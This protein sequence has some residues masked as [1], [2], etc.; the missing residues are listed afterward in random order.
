MKQFIDSLYETFTTKDGVDAVNRFKRQVN[1]I[2]EETSSSD[3][4]EYNF[5]K[6]LNPGNICTFFTD[7]DGLFIQDRND[8]KQTKNIL[9]LFT[10][11]IR[12]NS[13]LNVKETLLQYM[14]NITYEEVFKKTMEYSHFKSIEDII[15]FIDLVGEAR[16]TFERVK[17]NNIKP[18]DKEIDLLNLKCLCILIWKGINLSK[19]CKIK[20]TD[21]I[22]NGIFVD[23]NLIEFTEY[24]MHYVLNFKNTK[25]ERNLIN[26]DLMNY[27]DGIYLF[28]KKIA[29]K[30]D[31]PVTRDKF[32]IRLN[33]FNHC[34]M[35]VGAFKILNVVA[36][37][38][39]GYYHSLYQQTK[40]DTKKA[41]L[42][43]RQ[44]H[45]IAD[46]SY[47]CKRYLIWY[48]KFYKESNK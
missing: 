39:C 11:W 5:E 38:S 16:I 32:S 48:E 46:V 12:N 42:I 2:I 44:T 19:I 17:N 6:I 20:D 23:G 3:I 35:Y 40:H 24:E 34:A 37:K 22:D 15:N 30:K 41:F 8:F 9:N 31:I 26:F 47:I 27:R 36:I 4:K 1:K 43:I 28:K 25:Y 10:D 14:Q 33:E 45:Q 21:I 7:K 29:T 18:Y 13:S